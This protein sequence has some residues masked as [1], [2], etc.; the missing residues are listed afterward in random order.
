MAELLEKRI[1]TNDLKE[2]VR[3]KLRNGWEAIMRDNKRGNYRYAEVFGIWHETGEIYAHDI[4][5]VKIDEIWYPVQH[6]LK[7]KQMLIQVNDA[8]I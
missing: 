5:G 3:V 8:K 7:Q 1:Y 4:V 6:T 2:G